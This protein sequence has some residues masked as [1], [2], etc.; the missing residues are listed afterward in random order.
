[1]VS[2]I[3]LPVSATFKQNLKSQ[4]NQQAR[5]LGAKKN[6]NQS[7]QKKYKQQGLMFPIWA[8]SIFAVLILIFTTVFFVNQS[9][10]ASVNRSL[11][12]GF[13][14]DY[15]FFKLSNTF[16]LEGPLRIKNDQKYVEI[17]QGF[18]QENET[19]LWIKTDLGENGLPLSI[20]MDFENSLQEGNVISSDGSGNYTVQFAQ[21]FTQEDH[22]SLVINSEIIIKINWIKSQ[23]AGLAPTMVMVSNSSY[24]IGEADI[25]PCSIVQEK[26]NI[27]VEAAFRDQQGMHVQLSLKP[28]Q[29]NEGI[30][31]VES[32]LSQTIITDEF[33]RSYQAVI[34]KC[35]KE[36][37]HQVTL[38]FKDVSTLSDIYQLRFNGVQIQQESEK[39][40]LSNNDAIEI[41]LPK[42]IPNFEPTPKIYPTAAPDFLPVPAPNN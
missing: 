6:P 18:S 1:M 11:G 37:C 38:L 22:P 3:K 9:A 12:Y 28:D 4:L 36:G 2:N 13:L 16:L 17:N 42:S 5:M 8:F 30:S 14:P 24:D 39:I 27:C 25:Y 26:I 29:N 34:E 41:K 32:S 20:M 33:Q 7:K 10:L 19:I 40:D 35:V 23:F 21:E 31:W 15:G